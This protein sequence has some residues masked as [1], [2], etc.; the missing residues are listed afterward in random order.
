M[1]LISVYYVMGTIAT[2]GY[3]DVHA[4]T[5][6]KRSPNSAEKIFAIGL[7]MVGS[8]IYSSSLSLASA[9]FSDSR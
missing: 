2:V 3:G 7:L 8:W 6:G 9:F 4:E 5:I 1:Y